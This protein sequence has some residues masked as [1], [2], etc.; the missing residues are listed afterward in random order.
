MFSDLTKISKT[1]LLR[2]PLSKNKP[3]LSPID[4]T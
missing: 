4:Q 1:S 3:M 2:Q